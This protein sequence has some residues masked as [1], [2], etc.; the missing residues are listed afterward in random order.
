[1]YTQEYITSKSRYT[2]EKRYT[3]AEGY[4]ALIWAPSLTQLNMIA[5]K[6]I[7][8]IF[9]HIFHGKLND[10]IAQYKTNVLTSK[11]YVFAKL[12]LIQML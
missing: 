10:N 2:T 1:M 11:L 4:T 12:T 7:L 8:H 3:K 5:K 6:L 9:Y